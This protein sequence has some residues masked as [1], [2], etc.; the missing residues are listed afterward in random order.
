MD[1]IEEEE[2]IDLVEEGDQKKLDEILKKLD[3]QKKIEMEKLQAEALEKQKM[4]NE[5]MGEL[6][7][8]KGFFWI[9]T[10][11]ELMGA[12]QGAGNVLR[13][14]A[15]NEWM[16]N[17]QEVWEGGPTE[18]IVRGHMQNEKGEEYE[19]KDRRQEIVFIGH[20]MNKDV[21]QKILDECLLTEE[22][23]A[24]GPEK[25][26]ETMDEFD[27][28]R[29]ELEDPEA[30]YKEFEDD[31]DDQGDENEEDEEDEDESCKDEECKDKDKA[32]AKINL[33]EI[34]R[35]HEEKVKEI[36]I[37][38]DVKQRLWKRKKDP[39]AEESLTDGPKRK[40]A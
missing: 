2:E 24:M 1:P 4:R 27:N 30:A 10:S 5:T 29:L 6:L 20:R 32:C 22:E 36:N 34:N 37:R 25:W 19:Y 8:S 16:C 35:Q 33:D 9:A 3:K 15:E 31:L 39:F 13:M 11:N 18:D 14:K 23:M 17:L 28:I 26:K 40:K 21:I 12:W 38:Q 7:R